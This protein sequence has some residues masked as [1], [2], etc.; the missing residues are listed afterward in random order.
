MYVNPSI[1]F[2]K[3]DGMWGLGTGGRYQRDPRLTNQGWEE[4]ELVV[5]VVLHGSTPPQLLGKSVFGLHRR[6]V[7]STAPDRKKDPNGVICAGRPG[8]VVSSKDA[9]GP[10]GL[11]ITAHPWGCV[12]PCA[13][14]PLKSH[15]GETRAENRRQ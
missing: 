12:C 4:V 2:F 8:K 7:L 3:T 11:A 10:Q 9:C 13:F 6:L 5:T 1:F 15:S 14:P